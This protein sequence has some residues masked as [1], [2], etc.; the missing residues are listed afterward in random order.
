MIQKR[1]WELFAEKGVKEVSIEEI[2]RELKIAKKT[3]YKHF[4][5]KEALIL[6]IVR[7]NIGFLQS[8]MAAAKGKKQSPVDILVEL[9][10]NVNII[11][12]EKNRNNI[13]NKEILFFPLARKITDEVPELYPDI[14]REIDLSRKQIIRNVIQLLDK[15]KGEYIKEGINVSVIISLL[16]TAVEKLLTPELLKEYDLSLDEAFYSVVNILITGFINHDKQEEV[17]SKIFQF[18][19]NSN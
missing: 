17:L 1:A 14:W 3:F 4:A 12:A 11:I 2:C 10:K 6:S 7:T 18:D 5:D 13:D 19:M 8:S 15:E 9:L 16:I